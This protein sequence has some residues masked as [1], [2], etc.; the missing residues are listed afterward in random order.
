MCL[1]AVRPYL[2]APGED[3]SSVGRMELTLRKAEGADR[4]EGVSGPPASEANLNP[5]LPW[6]SLQ[7]NG[8]LSQSDKFGFLP[9]EI[10]CLRHIASRGCRLACSAFIPN[11][12]I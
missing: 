8:V 11:G 9:V 12:I 4:E 1:G 2:Q 5:A 10:P 7:V 6:H 3:E